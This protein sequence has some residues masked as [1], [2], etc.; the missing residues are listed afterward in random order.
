MCCNSWGHKESDRTERLIW[1]DLIWLNLLQCCLCVTFW[2]LGQEAYEISAPWPR[3]EPLLPA[4]EGEVLTTG[5][6]EKSQGL[7]LC[8]FKYWNKVQ[9]ISIFLKDLYFLTC[10]LT[11][12]FFLIITI[13]IFSFQKCCPILGYKTK[14]LSKNIEVEY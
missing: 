7:T 11:N 14:A 13:T 2:F 4:L 6:P 3:I 8:V 12:D 10:L 5:L 1:S 9:L